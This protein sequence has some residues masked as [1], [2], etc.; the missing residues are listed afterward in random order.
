MEQQLRRYFLALISFGFIVTWMAVGALAAFL[1]V[2]AAVAVSMILPAVF[3]TRH[4]KQRPPRRR[5]A[6]PEARSVRARPLSEE[7]EE[8]LPLVPDEP[9]L[10]IGVSS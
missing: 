8:E 7:G 4:S 5:L 6:D 1:G 3:G 10:I 2:L 9:S